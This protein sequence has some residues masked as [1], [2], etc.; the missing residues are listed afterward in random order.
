M[1]HPIL[2]RSTR[3]IGATSPGCSRCWDT[4]RSASQERRTQLRSLSSSRTTSYAPSPPQQRRAFASSR[5][6]WYPRSSGGRT[7]TSTS[8]ST[9]VSLYALPARIRTTP[10]EVACFSSSAS[11]RSDAA[12]SSSTTQS[13]RPEPP[14]YLDEKE[15][16]IF[17][18]LNEGLTPKELQVRILAP[19]T[20]RHTTRTPVCLGC[21]NL[22]RI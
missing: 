6:P 4:L 19:T 20:F 10:R 7:S 1:A 8:K 14:D 11:V 9:S 16:A 17:D 3:S 18:K 5:S 2:L 15:R 22:S 21:H 12:P 13:G